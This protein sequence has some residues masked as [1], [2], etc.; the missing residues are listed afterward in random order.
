MTD[1]KTLTSKLH[2]HSEPVA[3]RGAVSGG[4]KHNTGLGSACEP[5]LPTRLDWIRTDSSS[6]YITEHL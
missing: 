5:P 4:G 6:T 2:P 3:P 1:K